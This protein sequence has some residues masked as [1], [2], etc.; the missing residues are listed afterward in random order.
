M[1]KNTNLVCINLSRTKP[2]RDFTSQLSTTISKIPMIGAR[3]KLERSPKGFLSGLSSS[4]S[5]FG[6]SFF[7]GRTLVFSA[8]KSS[9]PELG[10]SVFV[11]LWNNLT[12][13]LSSWL[14]LKILFKKRNDAKNLYYCSD[15]HSNKNTGKYLFVLSIF[16]CN[17]H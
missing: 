5:G 16:Y 15:I 7:F 2:M 4:L 9:S 6:F 8:D 10:N 17:I 1:I 12:N 3:V 14:K 13:A 11:S